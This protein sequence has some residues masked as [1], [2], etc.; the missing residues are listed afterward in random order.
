[1]LFVVGEESVDVYRG[2]EWEDSVL[3]RHAC[4][5]AGEAVY[6]GSRVRRGY[7]EAVGLGFLNWAGSTSNSFCK[8]ESLC[9]GLTGA[10]SDLLWF[11]HTHKPYLS[12]CSH[13]YQS[14]W[15]A[16]GIEWTH[17][18][19]HC[20][21]QNISNKHTHTLNTYRAS[22]SSCIVSD[23]WDSDSA[24]CLSTAAIHFV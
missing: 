19:N 3:K 6:A 22:L 1:M 24:L 10:L 7:L 16:Y 20:Y 21:T 23:V 18:H 5:R 8:G 13:T 9:G 14:T 17:T 11:K 4:P 12:A 15:L 2:D